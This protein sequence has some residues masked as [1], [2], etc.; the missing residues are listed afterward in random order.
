M[1]AVVHG[2]FP[3]PLYINS[4]DIEI[5]ESLLKYVNNLEICNNTSNWTSKNNYI[6]EEPIFKTI[7]LKLEQMLNE[8]FINIMGVDLENKLKIVITQ[9]WVNINKKNF[10][11]HQH[12]HPNSIVS[13]VVYLQADKKVDK[14][15]FLK[16]D[17]EFL[18]FDKIR[19]NEYNSEQ[20]SFPINKGDVVLFPSNLMHSVDKNKTDNT[21]I[22]LSFNTFVKGKLGKR[23]HLN[24][25]EL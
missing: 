7:K 4:L 1:T 13:G 21:R 16:N 5:N 24:E 11:H 12:C 14:I 22:S 15:N 9:S 10:S 19:W 6:L 2:I 3:T 8:Y 25:L 18:K 20:Y 17:Y 23:S